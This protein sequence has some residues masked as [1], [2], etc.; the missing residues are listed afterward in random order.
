MQDHATQG[1]TRLRPN[2]GSSSIYVCIFLIS[3]I[4]RFSFLFE[5]GFYKC[6]GEKLQK[7]LKKHKANL[8]IAIISN[9]CFFQSKKNELIYPNFV[10]NYSWN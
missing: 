9:N 7:M 6:V 1:D 2:F 4:L 5:F 8:V 3:W 10:F